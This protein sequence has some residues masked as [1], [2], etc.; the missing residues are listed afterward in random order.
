MSDVKTLRIDDIPHYEGERGIPG[1]KFRTAGRA[2][3]V[4]AWGMNVLEIEPG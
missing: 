4:S 1:I 3:D 2:L